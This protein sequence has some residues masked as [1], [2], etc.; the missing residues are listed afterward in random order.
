MA[1][2]LVTTD[3]IDYSEKNVSYLKPSSKIYH[4]QGRS[5]D[6]LMLDI[7]MKGWSPTHF[8]LWRNGQCSK[9]D[10]F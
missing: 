8:C 9:M 4:L 6:V 1:K 5:Y 7:E 10:F 3:E 2:Y